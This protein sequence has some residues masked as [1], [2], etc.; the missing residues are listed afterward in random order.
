MMEGVVWEIF[1]MATGLL[2]Y[3]SYYEEYLVLHASRMAATWEKFLLV[4]GKLMACSVQNHS[5]TKPMAWGWINRLRAVQGDAPEK[6][7]E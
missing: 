5:R 3:T 6:E 4:H 1:C 2:L 7:R